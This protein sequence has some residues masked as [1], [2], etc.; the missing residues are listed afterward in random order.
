MNVR[1]RFSR[2]GFT[3]VELVIAV[4]GAGIVLC[5]IGGA[6]L[7]WISGRTSVEVIG[8]N[9]AYDA[10]VAVGYTEPELIDTYEDNDVATFCFA[11]DDEIGYGMKATP[12]DGGERT[13]LIVCCP[14]TL[15]TR[16]C[17]MSILNFTF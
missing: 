16:P 9:R 4:I 6:V 2:K 10:V 17:T 1:N 3:M 14:S 7:V 15:S 11:A 12:K 13:P 5:A 8:A